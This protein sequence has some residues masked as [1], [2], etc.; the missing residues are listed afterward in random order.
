M[1]RFVIYGLTEPQH[2]ELRYVGKSTT[3][4]VQ[5]LASHLCPSS[6]RDRTRK[7]Q[8]IKSLLRKGQKPDV[9]VIEV[10]ASKVDLNEAE[11]HHIAVLRGLG[12]RLTNG[13]P[14][15]D[16][17]G[18]PCPP[19]VRAKISASQVGK[20]GVS[21]SADRRAKPSPNFGRKRSADAVKATADALRGIPRPAHV[22][23][24]IVAG[25]RRHWA[26]GSNREAQSRRRGGRAIL[27][28]RGV[29]HATQQAAARALGL[30]VSHINAVLKGVRRTTGG[31]S[32]T[33]TGD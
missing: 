13:T 23:A 31:L 19:E 27:D 8:W 5:R 18:R 9:F 32:F 28:S 21:W 11:R 10:C 24:A 16:G 2:G 12:C 14:G 1:D 20:K 29:R 6:L 22:K 26:D 30:N 3:G 4:A 33:Y 17:E 15:G 25:A 7:N